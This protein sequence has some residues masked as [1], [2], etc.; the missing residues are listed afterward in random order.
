MRGAPEPAGSASK[1]RNIT[2]PTTARNDQPS[3]CTQVGTTGISIHQA[4]PSKS[5]PNTRLT[6]SIQGPVRGNSVPADAPTSSSGMPMPQAIANRAAPPRITSPVCEMYSN[7]PASGA[8]TQGPTINADSA[9]MTRAPVTRP[10]GIRLERSLRR[11]CRPAGIWKVKAPNIA[12]ARTASRMANSDRIHGVCS[13]AAR[14]APLRPAA[15]PSA[16]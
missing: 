6:L 5:I 13:H 2:A 9:P 8:A 7:A 3:I 16:V 11:A 1:A 12:S 10:P 4:V 14:P 15:T